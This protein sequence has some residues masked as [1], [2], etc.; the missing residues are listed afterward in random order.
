MR[1]EDNM[2]IEHQIIALLSQY[3]EIIDMLTLSCSRYYFPFLSRMVEGSMIVREYYYPGIKRDQGENESSSRDL[4]GTLN[5]TIVVTS[6]VTLSLFSLSFWCST[7]FNLRNTNSEC[8]MTL[9][10]T[11][12]NRT[13][14]VRLE[15]NYDN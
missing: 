8:K 4:T 15:M 11:R 1:Y 14:F 10:I 5:N 12:V 13:G 3:S 6:I 2:Q 9:Y 7:A